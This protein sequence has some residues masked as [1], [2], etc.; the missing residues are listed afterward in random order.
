VVESAEGFV[1]PDADGAARGQSLIPLFPGALALPA[2]N[3]PLYDLLSIV[4]ALRI[5]TT[6]VRS[7]AS[8]LLAERIVASKT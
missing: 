8:A 2:R 5:G 4:D 1:W 7:L 3:E 6:R